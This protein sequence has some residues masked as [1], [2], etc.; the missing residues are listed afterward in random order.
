MLRLCAVRVQITLL[1]AAIFIAQVRILAQL[2]MLAQLNNGLVIVRLRIQTD[3]RIAELHVLW[4]LADLVGVK[5]TKGKTDDEVFNETLSCS[6]S[7]H[8][9]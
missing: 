2:K 8:L 5:W 4:T 9:C 7:S 3:H 1:I 6:I